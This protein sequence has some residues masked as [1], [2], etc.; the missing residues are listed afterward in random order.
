MSDDLITLDLLDRYS[1]LVERLCMEVEKLRYFE[2]HN[3]FKLPNGQQADENTIQDFSFWMRQMIVESAL[4]E[5]VVDSNDA[6]LMFGLLVNDGIVFTDDDG[7]VHLD[8]DI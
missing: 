3:D 6:T 4:S 8:I 5:N 1:L 2:Q 7:D